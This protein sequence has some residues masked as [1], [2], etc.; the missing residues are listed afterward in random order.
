MMK[1]LLV[2][3]I[4]NTSRLYALEELENQNN[5]LSAN[6]WFLKIWNRITAI[7]HFSLLF[8]SEVWKGSVDIEALNKNTLI[9]SH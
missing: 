2:D 3:T 6:Y 1:A 5:L 7:Q 8:V 4:F 9:I